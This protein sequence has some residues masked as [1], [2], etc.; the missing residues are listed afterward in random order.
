MSTNKPT[1]ENNQQTITHNHETTKQNNETDSMKLLRLN[2][3][4]IL[5]Q[6]SHR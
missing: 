5:N 3:A 2:E 6:Y 4:G 1:T